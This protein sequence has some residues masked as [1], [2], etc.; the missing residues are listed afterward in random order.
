M[1]DIHEVIKRPR[2]SEKATLLH[3]KTGEV[4]FEVAV[5]ATKVEIRQ[6]VEKLLGK[7]VASVR[8]ANYDGKE[9]RKRTKNHGVTPA[10]KKAYAKLAAGEELELV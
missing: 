10:W 2:V 4:V 8:T 5:E 7:K 6:A 3:E 9:R 1:N